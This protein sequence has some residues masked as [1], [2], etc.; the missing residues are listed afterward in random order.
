MKFKLIS[1]LLGSTILLTACTGGMM[2]NGQMQG[3]DHDKMMSGTMSDT[4][5][6]SGTMPM[7]HE[8]MNHEGM[9]ADHTQMMGMMEQMSSHMQGMLDGSMPADADAM[10]A[11]MGEM[12]SMMGMMNQMH[13]MMMG[14]S[15]PME[16]QSHMDEMMGEMNSMTEL[17]NQMHEK[18]A[19]GSMPMSQ[20]H[21]EQMQKHMTEMSGMMEMMHSMHGSMPMSDTMHMSGT[22]PMSGTMAGMDHGAMQMDASKPID[23]QFIDGMIVHHQGAVDMAN[24][25]LQNAEHPELKEFANAIIAAQTQEIADMESWREAWYPDLAATGGMEMGMGDMEISDDASKPFDQRFLEAMISHHQGAIDMSNMVLQMTPEH[26][27]VKT[28]AEAIIVAQQAEIEQMKS[29][30]QEWYNQ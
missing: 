4:M 1:A 13:T 26:E 18:M 23:A 30:L 2:S 29:W 28:L 20:D 8:T 24:D 17:M 5:P 10:Q 27:E 14:G 12:D 6:M 9:M 16:D 22:M 25:V 21:M 3:M 19:D 15:M 7:N 11:M